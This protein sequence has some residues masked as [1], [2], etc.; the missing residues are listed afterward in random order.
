[1]LISKVP[2]ERYIFKV[3]QGKLE[4][5]EITIS[6]GLDYNDIKPCYKKYISLNDI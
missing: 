3:L 4:K 5:K 1:M 2:F 6:L